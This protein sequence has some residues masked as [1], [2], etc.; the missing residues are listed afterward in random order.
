MNEQSQK[1]NP[2]TGALK[3]FSLLC[4]ASVCALI[5]FLAYRYAPQRAEPSRRLWWPVV[6]NTNGSETVLG[7]YRQFEFWTPS[8]KTK[9]YLHGEGGQV[10][11]QEKWEVLP[12]E[13]AV[14][15]FGSILH[16]NKNVLGY[17]RVEVMGQGRTSFKPGWWWTVNVLNDYSAGEMGRVYQNFWKSSQAVFIEVID[18]RGHTEE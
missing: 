17:R 1:G 9:D 14:L 10:V 6:V 8:V 18:N 3:L 2:S 11:V 16:S 13:D 15:Q 4:F 5:G 7:D 12:N